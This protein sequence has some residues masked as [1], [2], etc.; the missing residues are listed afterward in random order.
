MDKKKILIAV[1][2][3]LFII[4]TAIYLGRFFS[5]LGTLIF[6][7]SSV[8]GFLFIIL[9]F[10]RDEI[11]YP[12]VHFVKWYIPIAGFAMLLSLRSHAGWGI[13][14]IFDTEIVTMWSAGLF[15]F[16]SVI[17]MLVKSLK[18]RDK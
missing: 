6:S 3:I 9:Y 4:A 12:W 17:L 1:T 18:L 8:F 5:P 11:F 15:F 13:G 16:L 14:N 2:S 10:L 7:Y